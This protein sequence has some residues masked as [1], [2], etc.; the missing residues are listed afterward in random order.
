V[1]HKMGHE[2]SPETLRRARALYEQSPPD[3]VEGDTF[4]TLMERGTERDI[5]LLQSYI[6]SALDED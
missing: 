4:D 3:E 2:Y 1:L 6:E 5:E